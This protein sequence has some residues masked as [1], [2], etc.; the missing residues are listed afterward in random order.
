MDDII[1]SVAHPSCPATGQSQVTSIEPSVLLEIAELRS[2][3]KL[4]SDQVSFLLSYVGVV[5]TPPPPAISVSDVM[6]TATTTSLSGLNPRPT[7]N[8]STSSSS[9]QSVIHTNS[10]VFNDLQDNPMSYASAVQHSKSQ[11]SNQLR[12]AVVSAVYVDLHSKTARENNIIVSGLPVTVNTDDKDVILELFHN[13]F[14]LKPTIKQCKRIG[15][16]VANKPQRL[17]VTLNSLNNVKEILCNAKQLRN[18]NDSFVSA[19]IFIN[20]DLTKAEATVAYEERCRRRQQR[21][22]R[23]LKQQQPLQQQSTHVPNNIFPSSSVPTTTSNKSIAFS[24]MASAS[25]CAVSKND[26]QL[27]VSVPEFQ[28]ASAL[29]SAGNSSPTPHSPMPYISNA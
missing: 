13:E 4:L 7:I 26:T 3:V 14:N 16:A 21:K 11:L 20:A 27:N 9:S 24:S 19:N 8:Q 18:S 15:K 17:L 10:T 28:P 29:Q 1:D 2:I 22:E 12:Q 23:S 6:Q 25:I 5:D